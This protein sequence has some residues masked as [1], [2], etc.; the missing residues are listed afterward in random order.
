R[1]EDVLLAITLQQSRHGEVGELLR[2]GRCLRI[3]DIPRHAAVLS[4]AAN[5]LSGGGILDHQQGIL[6]TE[7]GRIV[8]VP[9]SA[10]DPARNPGSIVGPVLAELAAQAEYHAPGGV[11]VLVLTRAPFDVA[12][13]HEQLHIAA[14]VGEY[15]VRVARSADGVEHALRQERVHPRVAV[16]TYAAVDQPVAVA[17]SRSRVAG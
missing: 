10:A 6:H 11:R 8:V 15:A 16:S 2:R 14:G 7:R 3:P 1:V 9:I 4:T 12:A 17:E 13:R 5:G